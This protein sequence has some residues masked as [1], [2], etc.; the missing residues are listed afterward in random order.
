MIKAIIFDYFGVICD[1]D[2]WRQIKSHSNVKDSFDRLKRA[3]NTGEM[4]WVDF[5]KEMADKTSESPQTLQSK[6]EAQRINP[7]LIG[8]ISSL[9]ESYKIALLT[10]VSHGFLEPL[11][12]SLHLEGYFDEIVMSSR[13]GMIKPDPRL[14]MHLLDKLKVKPAEAVFIDDKVINVEAARQ[15]GIKAIVYKNLQQLKVELERIL[16]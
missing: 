3:V 16:R 4:P 14:F 6:Y 7:Q 13:V 5:I 8:Y 1:D 2:Y 11:L 12:E 10:N 9:H 15:L